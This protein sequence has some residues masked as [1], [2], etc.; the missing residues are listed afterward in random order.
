MHANTFFFL[1]SEEKDEDHTSRQSKDKSATTNGVGGDHSAGLKPQD[2]N[3]PS[4]KN[5]R[6][7]SRSGG[8]TDDE[9]TSKKTPQAHNQRSPTHEAAETFYPMTST[10]TS[11]CSPSVSN[12]SDETPSGFQ[13]S[14]CLAAS[15][16]KEST[17]LSELVRLLNSMN[18]DDDILETDRFT[19][20]K[21]GSG[22]S[23]E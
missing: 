14:Q 11:D 18:S 10:P 17:R 22:V 15:S 7:R 1:L 6:K 23:S 19:E 12:D 3:E 2:N 13:L 9:E 20:L 21:T 16:D 8:S 4:A 5:S